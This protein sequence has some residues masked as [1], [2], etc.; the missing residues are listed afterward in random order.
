MR[1]RGW[2]IAVCLFWAVGVQA[3][4]YGRDATERA[5]GHMEEGQSLYLQGRNL[6]AAAEFLAAYDARPSAAFLYNAGIAFERHGAAARAIRLYARYA[7]E[8]RSA[9]DRQDVLTRIEN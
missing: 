5:R 4:A 7:A 3:Q 8:A 6:E 1:A 2:T 9:A